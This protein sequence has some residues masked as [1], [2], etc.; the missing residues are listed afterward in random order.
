ML[1]PSL[2]TLLVALTLGSALASPGSTAD[3][4]AEAR[5]RLNAD[6]GAA[7]VAILEAALPEARA[8][9]DKDA[10][11]DL[12]R[13]S[14]EAAAKRAQDAGKLA[15]ADGYRENLKILTRKAKTPKD[16]PAP[17]PAP[18]V[19]PPAAKP[20]RPAE[21]APP[22]PD[23]TLE[24]PTLLPDLPADRAEPDTSIPPALPASTSTVAE[25]ASPPGAVKPTPADPAASD[26]ADAD[27]AFVA[28]DYASAGRIYGKLALAKR[29]PAERRDQWFYCRAF[30]VVT[31]INARPKEESEW[32]SINGEIDQI[33][34]LNPKNY[35]GEYLRN[36]AA[37]RQGPAR[38]PRV[39]KAMVVRGSAPEEP[40]TVD[41]PVRPAS[42]V[43]VADPPTPAKPAAAR[44]GPGVAR[45]QMLDTGNFRIYHAD[46][47]LAN[48]VGQAAEAA[49]RDL[50]KRWSKSTAR[51]N[52]QPP[53]EIYLYPTAKQY[54]TM[55]GQPEDSPGFSTM[56]MNAGR[57][58]SRRIN[59]R[60]D[61]PTLVQAVLPHEITHVILADHF[62]ERQI[63]RWADEG[64]AVL[65]EP[66]DEQRRRA[67]DL[68]KP[69]G[70]NRVFAIDALMNMDYPDE[71]Y[72]NLYYA[73][74]VSLTRFLVEQGTPAQMIQFLQASQR[75]GYEPALRRVYK[76][77][78]FGDLQRRWVPYARARAAEQQN[79]AA[80]QPDLK[81]R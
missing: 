57:I 48:K 2:A 47:A 40:A 15:D 43:T 61:H 8:G 54:A 32:A 31:R 37:E 17:T 18:A 19:E 24:A 81:V 77:E 1:G 20:A 80:T 64:L 45:W 28:E 67:A 29:L 11:L 69:L 49:R 72:W 3:A 55:T 50:M 10:V 74:S 78:G 22:S 68:I 35:L 12:L 4:L 16:A 30:A 33:R 21:V 13:R 41:R 73:Q 25:P 75:D 44:V 7:A 38:K 66:D 5:G 42:N 62:T 63:P 26:L 70:D 6:D 59:L 52:W 51:P 76:I 53:C 79:V 36:L 58:T 34:A 14:Y 39:S 60:A 9:Q 56:G 46:P 65:S 27:A 23:P 71:R